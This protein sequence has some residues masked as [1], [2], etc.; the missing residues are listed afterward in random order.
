MDVVLQ[1]P[2]VQLHHPIVEKQGYLKNLRRCLDAYV[3][4]RLT[5]FEK[6]GHNT[7]A[8]HLW[9]AKPSLSMPPAP[10]PGR[11]FAG[12]LKKEVHDTE[13]LVD[14]VMLPSGKGLRPHAGKMVPGTDGGVPYLSVP[15]SFA[16]CFDPQV[17]KDTD[18]VL[19]LVTEKQN[20]DLLPR[21]SHSMAHT[22]ARVEELLRQQQ[23]AEQQQRGKEGKASIDHHL[24]PKDSVYVLASERLKVHY[25][26]QGRQYKKLRL[27]NAAKAMDCFSG[28]TIVKLEVVDVQRV[29]ICLKPP[30]GALEALPQPVPAPQQPLA[31]LPQLPPHQQRRRLEPR[32]AV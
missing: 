8:I 5:R 28:W 7:L 14:Y 1:Q 23:L 6:A 4:M 11:G 19:L 26:G 24:T 2:A 25:Q 21:R 30:V 3:G 18:V 13:D 16:R 27:T 29:T 10:S 9:P 32:G 15:L 12:R 20:F 17:T 22:A 31:P